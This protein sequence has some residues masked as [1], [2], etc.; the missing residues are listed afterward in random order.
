MRSIVWLALWLYFAWYAGALAAEVLPIP[1][2]AGL[3]IGAALVGARLARRMM[4]TEP[5][6]AAAS[7]A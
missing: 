1:G 3:V 4:Q 2:L 6:R 5:R 7:R